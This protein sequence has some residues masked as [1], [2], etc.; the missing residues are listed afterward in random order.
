MPQWL[1]HFGHVN[2]YRY[3]MF[4]TDLGCPLIRFAQPR[5][6]PPFHFEYFESFTVL[7]TLKSTKCFGDIGFGCL[8]YVRNGN[9]ITVVPYGN[10]RRDLSDTS[11]VY[12]FEKYALRSRRI[13]HRTKSDLVSLVRESRHILQLRVVPIHF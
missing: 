10:Y 8:Y 3:V 9:T 12:S 11:G 5:E 1:G 7:V 4:S 13:S 2:Q 6:V